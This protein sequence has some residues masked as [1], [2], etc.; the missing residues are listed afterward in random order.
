M[1]LYQIQKPLL[2]PMWGRVKGYFTCQR[3]LP[4]NF[5]FRPLIHVYVIEIMKKKR[6]ESFLKFLA[7]NQNNP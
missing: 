7:P 3:P 5:R 4:Q 1:H 6:F 2:Y